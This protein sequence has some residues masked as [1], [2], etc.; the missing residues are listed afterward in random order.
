[1]SIKKNFKIVFTV[2][3]LLISLSITISLINFVVSLQSTQQ[4]LVERSLPLSVDNIYS[5]I[6]TQVIGPGLVSSMMANDTFVR[7]W[8]IHDEEN[9]EKITQYLARIK[10]KYG[11]FVTFLVSEKTQNYYTH[12]GLLER[13][14]P[15][16][17]DN[18]WYFRFKNIESDH[19]INIDTNSEIDNTLFLFMNYKIFDENYQLIGVTG[20]GHKISYVDEMLKRF[21][22]QFK[23]NVYFVDENGH[24]VISESLEKKPHDLASHSSLGKLKDQL[25]STESVV[26]KYQHNGTDY[27]IK[28]KYIPELDLYLLVEAKLDDFI[29]DVENTFYINL[30]IS[31]MVTMIV[32]LLVLLSIRGYHRK[33][34]YLATSD[35][36]TELL[37]RRAFEERF[38]KYHSLAKRTQAPLSVLFFDIDDFKD[39][40]DALGHHTGDLV[41]KRIA[42]LM[43]THLRE[44]DLSARWGGEEFIVALINT[45]L[46]TASIVA[47]KLRK[48]IEQDPEMNRLLDHPVTASFGLSLCVYDQSINHAI[49][50]ADHAMY[51]SKQ[52]GKNQISVASNHTA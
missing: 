49:I 38:Q 42:L 21:R 32:T 10:N 46:S 37:N 15:H 22:R 51:E 41:L 44:D 50:E 39:I 6:Q 5:E 30:A 7:D 9:Q 34:E 8:L 19:E 2:S 16:K 28:T 12:N 33:L 3:V 47:E 27:L 18:K 25:I 35:T 26:L 29:N 17:E 11:M 43:Q 14:S 36:L 24:I 1:M 20:I 48:A 31:L 23:F 4:E 45:D 40:N 13:I 52:K